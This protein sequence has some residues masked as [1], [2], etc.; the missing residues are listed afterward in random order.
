MTKLVSYKRHRF[1]PQI[2]AHAVWLYFRFPLSL[3]LVEEM[4]LERGIMVSYETI[5]RWG[6]KFGPEYARRLRPKPPSHNDIWHLDEVVIST[7]GK[8]HWL[9]R[10]VGQDGYVLDKAAKRLLTRLLKRQGAAPKRIITDK[11]PSYGSA[12]RQVMPRVEHRSHKGL[13]NRAE[14]SHVP[15]RK[16]ERIMQGSRSVGGLQRFTSVF[17]A[18]RNLFVPARS[19]QTALSTHIHRLRVMAEWRAAAGVLA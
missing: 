4:L 10:A 15:L 7:S 13:N 16:R 8:K 18:V 1:P 5:R 19:N 14:N 17:S 6:K 9:W 2:I 11:L 3:L 12:R